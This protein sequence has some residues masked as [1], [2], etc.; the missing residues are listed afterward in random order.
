MADLAF[1]PM[2][3]APL[4]V[5]G[6]TGTVGREVVRHLVA[7]GVDVRATACDPGASEAESAG[8][9]RFDYEAPETFAG[10]LGGAAPVFWLRPPPVSDVR[11]VMGPAMA[12]AAAHGAGRRPP[13]AVVLSVV[14]A[15]PL[16]PH[17]HLERLARRLGMPTTVLRPSFF[18][19]NLATAHAAE[20]R[21]CGEVFVPAGRGKTSFVDARD[22]GE[23]AARVMREGGGPAGVDHAGRTYTL[24]GSEALTYDE[25]AAILTR[26]LGRP[27]RYAR[28]SPRAFRERK[29]AEGLAPDFVATMGR[30][31]L[32]ARLGLAGG[33]APDLGRL[34]GRPPGTF[35]AFARDYAPVWIRG[36][37]HE[38]TS[39]TRRRGVPP[40][41]TG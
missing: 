2:S 28:P 6:A 40:R 8:A 12:Y 27:V 19:Q 1:L 14:G 33:L 29:T 32:V 20:V 5:T 9:V 16:V 21:D 25:V 37:A 11:G 7:A 24:T 41:G 17:W 13:H 22:I 15:N 36:G 18:M 23:A 34:L 38:D 39:S 30:I 4:V 35:E 10:A 26:V 31:Y 3:L